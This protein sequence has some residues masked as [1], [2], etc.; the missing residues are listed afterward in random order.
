MCMQS[1]AYNIYVLQ[2]IY[3]TCIL[4]IAFIVRIVYIVNYM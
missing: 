2:V 1:T 3:C 4:S